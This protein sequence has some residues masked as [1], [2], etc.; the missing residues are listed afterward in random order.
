MPTD[1][2][3]FG[4]ADDRTRVEDRPLLLGEGR[5]TDDID[6]PG[7]AFAA[8]VRSP[9]GHGEMRGIDCA[10]AR[11]MPGVLAIFTGADL[12]ADGIGPIPPVAVFPGRGGKA[13]FVAAMPVLAH[14]RVRY[15]GEPLAIVVAET[16]AA[17]EDAA[18]LVTLDLA[19]LPAVVEPVAATA[20][21]APALWPGA[22]DNIALDWVDGDE[23]AMAAAFSRAAH[24][25]RV[26]L[27]DTRVAPTA[28][29]PRAGI[30]AW[31]A[32][33]GP[34]WMW[35]QDM[36]HIAHRRFEQVYVSSIQSLS[37]AMSRGSLESKA[38]L[39][40]GTRLEFAVRSAGAGEA[41]DRQ[42]WVPVR[43]DGF[44]L[45]TGARQVQYRAT[46]VSDNGDRYPVL[47]RVHIKLLP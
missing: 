42:P 25:A 5:F 12:A 8:F 23:A 35:D 20:A 4:S 21:G 28:M 41:L 44:R 37:S 10:A 43:P 31:D 27:A 30:G 3:R 19:S 32:E 14:D 29:E 17:A 33:T 47:H 38:D 11:A 9:V 24:V 26:R 40:Q 39:P 46:F 7:Q 1:R 6:L 18:E 22:P 15:V 2:L 16:R 45:N 34:H 13:M 36:G